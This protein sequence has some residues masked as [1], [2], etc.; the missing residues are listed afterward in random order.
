M[1]IIHKYNLFKVL[2]PLNT[3]K[4]RSSFG[5]FSHAILMKPENPNEIDKYTE[6]IMPILELYSNKFNFIDGINR[7]A[8]RD[9]K[10]L[11]GDEYIRFTDD[12]KAQY[13]QLGE[14]LI[15]MSQTNYF[16]YYWTYFTVAYDYWDRYP[17]DIY[18]DEF[19]KDKQLKK[20]QIIKLQDIKNKLKELLDLAKTNYSNEF[21]ILEN[22]I[23]IKKKD[24]SYW[25]ELQE[26]HKVNLSLN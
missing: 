12:N 10:V 2:Y 23:S 9:L 18:F 26:I 13:I 3:P 22:F 21:E 4:E 7:Y 17:N 1:I 24:G 20:D 6:V 14:V 8:L 5:I 25:D 16:V 15:E 19:F 11:S